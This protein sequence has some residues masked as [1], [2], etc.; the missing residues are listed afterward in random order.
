MVGALGFVGALAGDANEAT[1]DPV[2]KDEA[3][4]LRDGLD[5]DWGFIP[6]SRAPGGAFLPGGCGSSCTRSC[7]GGRLAAIA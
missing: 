7:T 6:G 4:E 3:D 1:L 5:E 2:G